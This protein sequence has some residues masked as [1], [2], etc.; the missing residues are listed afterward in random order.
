M[1]TN[2][3]LKQTDLNLPPIPDGN[4]LRP[5]PVGAVKVE[6]LVTFIDANGEQWIGHNE[7]GL[8]RDGVKVDQLVLNLLDKNAIWFTQWWDSVHAEKFKTE[9]EVE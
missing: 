2:L 5:P 1:Q 8:V 3:A 7:A 9:P 6:M 4:V